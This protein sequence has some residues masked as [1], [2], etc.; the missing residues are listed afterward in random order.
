MAIIDVVK[1]NATDQVYAWKF[2]SQELATW[3]QLIVS[4]SQEAVM[5]LNGEMAGPFGP[6]R[7][8]LDTQNIPI[9]IDMLKIPFG[10]KSPYAAEVWF[11]QKTIPL[12]VKWGTPDPIQVLDP[13]FNVLVPVRAFG[14]LGLQIVNTKK[15]LLKLVGTMPSFS[16]EQM[17]SYF[18][19]VTATKVKTLIAETI[20]RNKV[21]VLEI[22]ALLDTVSAQLKERLNREFEEFGVQLINFYVSSVNVPE[23]NPAVMDL[24]NALSKRAEMGIIGYTYQQE[25]SFDVLQDA[26]GNPGSM[27]GGMMGAGMGLGMG[28]AL[29]SPM[30]N[31]MGQL[32]GQINTASP[33]GTNNTAGNKCS[34]CGKDLEPEV[35][36][37]GE[38]GAAVPSGDKS[39]SAVVKCPSCHA[40]NDASAKFCSECGA[41]LRKSCCGKSFPLS[42]KF[43]SECGKPL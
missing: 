9:L 28:M 29:G 18:R 35:K 11:I 14:Q 25:R 38:C 7:H 13:R 10:G 33:V 3:T 5:L 8:V 23:D 30:G 40:E 32:A 1:W 42:T 12:D 34:A 31:A 36:F 15:F 39:A 17:V 2:P 26:A 24:R 37:C 6:G 16:R 22:A 27:S 19:G 43:C 41:T 4:E 21:S 20:I